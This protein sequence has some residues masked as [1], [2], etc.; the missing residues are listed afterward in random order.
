MDSDSSRR[1]FVARSLAGLGALA[2]PG[3]EASPPPAR[4]LSV[5]CVGGHPDDPETGCGGTL[6]AYAELG[7]RA[8]VVYLTRGERGIPGR[9]LAEAAAIRSAEA[10]EACRLLGAR[11]LF[12]G[13]IDGD[14]EVSPTRSAELARLLEAENPDVVFTHWPLDTHPDHQAASLLAFR[15]W[16]SARR[17]FALYFFEVNTGHQTLG[18]TPTDYVD[19]TAQRDKKRAALT[20]HRS[21]H[22]D[23]IVRQHVQVMEEFRGREAGVAGAEAFVRVARLEPPARL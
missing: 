6:A 13:Q 9:S 14:T 15:A 7:H 20:A 12:A 22:G 18:F 23:E 1:A 2:L 3:G 16:L 11:P 21:Q 4:P 8:T 5:V 17:R 19:V 10:T